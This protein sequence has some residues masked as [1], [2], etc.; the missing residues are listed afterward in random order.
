ME[1]RGPVAAPSSTWRTWHP[2]MLNAASS[3]AG[4]APAGPTCGPRPPGPGCCFSRTSAPTCCP[5]SPRSRSQC[6]RW[7]WRCQTLWQGLWAGPINRSVGKSFSTLRTIRT[8]GAS[9]DTQ[10][11]ASFG[12]ARPIR[13]SRRRAFIPW[14]PLTTPRPARRR[15]SLPMISGC[16]RPSNLWLMSRRVSAT[17]LLPS[18]AFWTTWLPSTR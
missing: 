18:G 16:L 9:S 11:G 6:R 13:E 7:W 14:S 2:A 3:W 4:L 8:G 1:V 12:S 15:I 17:T 5:A 10:S